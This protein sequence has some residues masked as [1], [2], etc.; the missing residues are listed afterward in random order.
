MP[1]SSAVL[2]WL[3]SHAGAGAVNKVHMRCVSFLLNKG[4]RNDACV[5]V[6]DLLLAD[7][8]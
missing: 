3:G 6:G 5:G 7:Q 4:K 8:R 1:L 2:I